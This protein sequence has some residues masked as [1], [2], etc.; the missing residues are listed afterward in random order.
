MDL[1]FSCFQASSGRAFGRLRGRAKVAHLP[2]D[3]VFRNFEVF[4]SGSARTGTWCR[5]G[6]DRRTAASAV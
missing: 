6:S 3:T 2:Y 4:S 5:T 1:C